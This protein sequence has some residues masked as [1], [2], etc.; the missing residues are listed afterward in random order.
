MKKFFRFVLKSI[1]WFFAITIL[2]VVIYRFVPPPITYLM[3]ERLVIQTFGSDD[4]RFK[5]DWEKLDNIS[6]NLKK[7]AIAAE[8]AHFFEHHGFDFEAIEKAMEKNKRRKKTIGASTI[9][10]QVAKNV[11]LWPGRSWL[12]KGFEVYFTTL[13]ELIWNKKRILEVYL[14]IIEMGNGIYGAEAASQFYYKKS[15]K[16]LSKLEAASIAAIFPNPRYWNPTKSAGFV[17]KKKQWILRN[18]RAMPPLPF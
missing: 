5:K 16:N 10:Q 9:S 13:I 14:N 8:D 17:G 11:F 18:M 7:A 4:I 15:A 12:R 1:L 6:D 2:W 3:V